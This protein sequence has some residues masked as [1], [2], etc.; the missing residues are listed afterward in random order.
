MVCSYM[1]PHV[2][3]IGCPVCTLNNIQS[4]RAK[5]LAQGREMASE[6]HEG[7]HSGRT[8]SVSQARACPGW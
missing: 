6:G 5:I 7:A 3:I 1:L 8:D 4:L 2:A